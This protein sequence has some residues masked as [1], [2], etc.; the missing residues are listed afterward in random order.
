MIFN[1]Q[2][3]QGADVSFYQDNNSTPQQ[4][5]FLKMVE[6]G[7]SFV[8]IRG[9]QNQWID[10][11]F[12]VNWERS[13]LSGLP[14]G[15]YWFYDSRYD[16]VKQAEIFASLF[17][18][19][20]PELRLWLDLEES[21]GGQYQ[22]WQNWK[23]FLQRLRA[24]LPN[25]KIGI[26][27]GYY[28]IQGKIPTSEYAYFA[29][30]ALWLAWYTTN[31]AV[32]LVPPPWS[33]VEFWQW[34]TPSWGIAW[35][36]ESTE[37][38]MNL[39]NGT[40]GDFRQ[41]FNLS[42]VEIPD[43]YSKVH[44]YNTD[45]HFWKG[46][47]SDKRSLVT[48]THGQLKRVSEVAQGSLVAVNADGWL[49]GINTPLSISA[50]DGDLYQPHQFDQ[51]PWLDIS[52]T[53]QI[54]MDWRYPAEYYNLFS[55]VR[56]IVKDGLNALQN[57]TNPEHISELSPRTAA[58]F[59]V[60]RKLVL[61]VAGG[62]SSDTYLGVTLKELGD[63]M[64]SA[65]AINAVDCDGGRSSGMAINGE[66]VNLTAEDAV[67]NHLVIYGG[68]MTDYY[69]IIGNDGANHRVRASY[70]VKATVLTYPNTTNSVNITNTIKAEA[71]ATDSDVY[72]YTSDVPDAT[73]PTGLLAK[74]GDKWRKVYK[75]GSTFIDG[76]T[77]E[78][79]LG[80]RQG[81]TITSITTTPPP[82]DTITMDV[83][84]YDVKVAG[85][86]YEAKGVKL[87]KVT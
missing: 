64:L 87:T 11:D 72:T 38:D 54:R 32:V 85:D 60:D 27:T 66:I 58:G 39:F 63:L 76:W 4:I 22:G 42:Q 3:V 5:N 50:S 52:R 44:K 16:P 10:P 81:I 49:D 79:H 67:A 37:I 29:Q 82:S 51:R 45:I 70:N 86:K 20:M 48:N 78:I 68:G 25:V 84:A 8:I 12:V 77:A 24:I 74:A 55:G 46:S 13:R 43:G 21:Y 40:L 73:M 14:R 47:L 15:S 26:Y 71:G 61:C 33:S 69:E 18:R 23:K 57:S 41:R 28:Y 59:T 17:M 65:G 53:G 2:G 19:D 62:W 31:P 80:V 34:G 36:C 83:T 1:N 9:G 56:F 7:A 6:Q 30:F 75:V 35:G